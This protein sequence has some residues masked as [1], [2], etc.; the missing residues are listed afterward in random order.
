MYRF[1]AFA[2]LA[3][4]AALAGAQS[5]TAPAPS[6]APPV[7]VAP[8]DPSHLSFMEYDPPSTL[9]VPGHPVTRAKY[10]FIDVHSHQFDLDEPAVRAI[11]AAMDE[12]NMGVLVNLSGRGDKDINTVISA[13]GIDRT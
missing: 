4:A 5:S 13:L 10:P 1:P 8:D 12:M 6:P 11:V 9:V 3:L 2:L 7:P